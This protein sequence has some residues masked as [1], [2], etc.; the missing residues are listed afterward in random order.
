MREALVTKRAD[1]KLTHTDM[2]LDAAVEA[3]IQMLLTIWDQQ[4]W[5]R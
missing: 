2:N 5:T 1:L 3:S 4:R